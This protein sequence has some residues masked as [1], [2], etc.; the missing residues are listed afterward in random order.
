[1]SL[2]SAQTGSSDWWAPGRGT[3]FAD[4]AAYAN[5]R[6]QVGVLNASGALD[7]K[8]HP[9]FEPIGTNGRACVTCH[10][11]ADGMSLSVRTVRERWEATAGK[12]PLFAAVDGMNC[13]HLPPGD[14]RSHSLL[15]ERGL[16]RVALPWPPRNPDGTRIDPEFT[17]DVVRDPGGCNTHRIY[18]LESANPTISVYRR[19]RP[20][21]NT[22]YTTHQNFGVGPFIAKS[23]LPTATDP[24]T[25]RPTSMNLMA[26][27]R[28]STLAVQAQD[29]AEHHLQLNGRLTAAQLARIVQFEE[30]VYAAQVSTTAAG[31]LIEAG[32][33]PAFGPRQLAAGDAGVLGDNTTR[34][35]YPMGRKWDRLPRP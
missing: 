14:P 5:D 3:S 24:A 35:V 6:G 29:A 20:A 21:A 28:A 34:Y 4:F 25:G 32:G 12:D 10:Q 17:I 2:A 26:D 15:L 16:I 7:P 22:K 18:G 33:P 23:G 13:P 11:P 31:S 27:A 30:Q 8:G 9:F 19:P 1:M